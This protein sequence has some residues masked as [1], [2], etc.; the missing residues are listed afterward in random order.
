[1]S[2]TAT[3]RADDPFRLRFEA[4]PPDGL[5]EDCVRLQY[6]RNGGPWTAV[7]A[8]DFPYPLRELELEFALRADGRLPPGWRAASLEE[9]LL[10]LYPAPWNVEDAFAFA[11]EYRLD[12]AGPGNASLVFGYADPDHHWRLT[13]DAEA[14]RVR[15]VRVVGGT[16]QLVAEQ[17]AAVRAGAWQQAEVKLEEGLLEI[18]FND[19]AVEFSL[20]APSSLPAREFGFLLPAPG[21]A[22]FR[23]FVIEGE[24]RSPRVSV[25]A[26]GTYEDGAPTA[27]LLAGIAAPHGGGS[28]VSLAACAPLSLAAGAH[29]E[30]EW[31]LVIRRFADGAV[32]NEPGDVFEFRL[33]DS[34]GRAVAGTPISIVTLDVP[35][36]HLGG[37]FVETPGRVGPWRTANGDLYF[38]MEPAESDNLF[39]MVKSTDGGRSWQEVDGANRPATGDLEAVDARLVGDTIHI[40]HQVT[41]ATFYHAFRTSGHADAPDTWAVTDEPATS[42]TARAQMATLVVRPDGTMVALHLGDTIG[43]SIRSTAGE[44]SPEVV[45]DHDGLE[46]AGP[47][48]VLGAGG[49]VHLAYY[50][51]DGTIWHRRLLPDDTLT[52]AQLLDDGAA[53]GEDHFGAVL[54]LVYRPENDTLVVLY[55][56]ADGR[57]YERR[58]TGTSPASPATLVAALPVV[59]HAVDSQQAGADAAGWDGGIVVAFIDQVDRSVYTT[60]NRGDGWQAP[61]LQ[62]EGIRGAWVRGNVYRRDD[63]ALVYGYVYDAGSEGGAGMNRYAELVLEPAGEP[64]VLRFAV[65]G[66]AEPKPEPEFPN[67]AAAVSDVNALAAD[68]RLDFVVGVGDI[69]HKGTLVQYENAAAVLEQLELP[70]YPIMGNEEHDSTTE[71]FLEFA[72]RWNN[73][74]AEIPGPRYTRDLGPL[75]MVHASPDHGRDFNDEGVAWVLAQVRAAYPRPVFLVVHGAQAGVYPENPDKGVANP[76]FAEVVAQPNLAAVISGDLHM[77]MDRVEHSKQL[78][79]VH[80][81]HIPA[82]ERTK[83]PD[84]TQH[85]PMFR[86]FTVTASGEVLVDTYQA[87]RPRPL[88]RHAYRFSLS[89]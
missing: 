50:G 3:V 65:L 85:T 55:R 72:N 1:M 32:T 43:Y 59:Q 28:G 87:G 46:T 62:V 12:P 71:R 30:L 37:T 22:E 64:V 67:L 27:D 56:R 14:G 10:A 81:L 58:I 51:L 86:V 20:P 83:I 33:A 78:G 49:I 15:V 57:L 7:E 74:Q 48:A 69:A 35:A 13:L 89:P 47:Q 17:P 36:G 52:E 5:D 24:P 76:A 80:Y 44:W 9:P 19:D 29:A 41:E 70:F 8:H 61:A 68:G 25:V 18:N 38:I 54:P 53:V 82:L 34:A 6:R 84:A 42:V 66:D 63:G 2:E 16:A 39:M 40:L 77:D 88:D 11:A 79:R 23:S 31:P 26:A 21:A 4:A 75:V 45:L 73:G 60:V